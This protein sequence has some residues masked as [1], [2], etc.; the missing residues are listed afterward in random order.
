MDNSPGA[1]LTYTAKEP[2]RETTDLTA[3][4]FT[5]ETM[6]MGLRVNM[7]THIHCDI[8]IMYNKKK[9][10]FLGYTP[11][12]LHHP[13]DNAG[14]LYGS[15]HSHCSISC[16]LLKAY[17]NNPGDKM[18]GFSTHRSVSKPFSVQGKNSTVLIPVIKRGILPRCSVGINTQPPTNN[19]Q[20]GQ[21]VFQQNVHWTD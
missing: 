21:M 11:N 5:L 14:V 20:S 9:K 4:F 1:H 7:A 17:F 10:S 18:L 16:I 3:K 6:T 8:K 13:G 15:N 2:L 19:L 12:N